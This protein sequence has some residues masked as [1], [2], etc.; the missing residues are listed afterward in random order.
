MIVS[1][2][3]ENLKFEE[4]EKGS[5]LIHK[6]WSLNS[7]FE[8]ALELVEVLEQ[9]KEDLKMGLAD[10][11]QIILVAKADDKI[12]GI[13]RAE[14]SPNRFYGSKPMGKIVEFY[15]APSHR[16]TGAGEALLNAILAKL[17]EREVELVTAEFPTQNVV[18]T[19]FYEKNGF[20]PFFT[21]YSKRLAED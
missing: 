13:V 11:N 5:D 19:S 18:A 7:E 16:R 20:A 9:I 21:V 4:M 17:S 14:I 15:V 12:I 2:T 10:K 1:V 8:P 6:F 3:I